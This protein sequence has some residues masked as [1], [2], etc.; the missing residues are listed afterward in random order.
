MSI[1]QKDP[2]ELLDHDYDGI[3]E[4]DNPL[5]NW[6]LMTFFGTIIFGFIYFLHYTFGGG[7]TQDMELQA[8]MAE[9]PKA[10]EMELSEEELAGKMTADTIASGKAVYASKCAACHGPE[11][12]G[13]IGPNLTDKFWLHGQGDRKSLVKVIAKGVTEKGMPAWT[14]MISDDEIV[15]VAGFVH[16]IK[17]TKPANPKEPQGVEVQ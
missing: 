2:N 5:P 14:G 13:L 10:V 11:G 17:D 12:Q 3:Q 1:D 4:Y 8:A 9:L 7:F 15:Q 6:W 16:S